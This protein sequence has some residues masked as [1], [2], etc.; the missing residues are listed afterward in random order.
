[1]NIWLETT[2]GDKIPVQGNCSI[3]R[4]PASTLILPGNQVSRRHAMIHS[5]GKG[6]YWLVDLGSSNGVLLNGRR[7]NR[8]MALKDQDKLEIGGHVLIFRQNQPEPGSAPAP[9]ETTSYMTIKA[10]RTVNLWLLIADIEGFTPLSQTMPGD[11]L[12]KLVGKWIAGCKEVIEKNGGEINKYLGDGF[13]AYWPYPET[14]PDAIAETLAQLKKLQ[15]VFL[16]A[17]KTSVVSTPALPFR[18]VVHYGTITIDNAL[19]EGEDSLI[20]PEVNFIFRLEKVAGGLKQ[21]CVVSEAAANLLKQFGPVTPH[22][23]HAMSG[24]AGK[25]TVYSY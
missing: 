23:E 19:S 13:L 17:E 8:P 24:F 7:A 15:A 6:E 16:E 22:G 3:G 4:D 12:A 14:Q 1:M 5:Q 25:H 20:G 10:S 11:V 2:S 9:A 18:L 21:H